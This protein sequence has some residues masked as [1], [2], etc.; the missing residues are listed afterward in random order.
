VA[1]RGKSRGSSK[2]NVSRKRRPRVFRG[3][4]R[5]TGK[6][7]ENKGC[8]A[9]V[10]GEHERA[11]RERQKG[12]KGGIFG[13]IN[14]LYASLFVKTGEAETASRKRGEVRKEL[15]EEGPRQRCAPQVNARVEQREQEL[16]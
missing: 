1:R 14:D 12:S 8:A 9:S 2:E 5:G 15:G 11:E 7:R 16:G 13:S 6:G 3:D 10:N 4:K